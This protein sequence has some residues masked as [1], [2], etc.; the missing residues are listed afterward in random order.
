MLYTMSLGKEYQPRLSL[1][2]DYQVRSFMQ[3]HSCVYASGS[4][5]VT[6]FKLH[7]SSQ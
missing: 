2:E 3:V 5:A 6:T 7:S 1:F 4:L